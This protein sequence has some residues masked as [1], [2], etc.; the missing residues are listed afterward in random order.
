MVSI[1]H[2]EEEIMAE[3]RV[4]HLDYLGLIAGVIKD[5]LNR[6]I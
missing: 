3:V 2:L 6:G 5:L 4:E 1:V